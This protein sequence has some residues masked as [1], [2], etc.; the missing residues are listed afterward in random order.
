MPNHAMSFARDTAL[1]ACLFVSACALGEVNF[2]DQRLATD[3]HDTAIGGF[4]GGLSYVPR[5]LQ[6]NNCGTP[7]TF[8]RCVLI[9]SRPEKPT[10]MVEELGSA[11]GEPLAHMSDALLDYSRLSVEHVVLPDK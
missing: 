9:A 7:D 3:R 10:V 8:K 4:A 6:P 5:P 11:S 2:V 1:C